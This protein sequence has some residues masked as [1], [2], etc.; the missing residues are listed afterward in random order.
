MTIF[1]GTLPP[2]PEG[3][4]FRRF[5]SFS[6]LAALSSGSKGPADAGWPLHGRRMTGGPRRDERRGA[7][8]RRP[9]AIAYVNEMKERLERFARLSGFT[10]ACFDELASTNDTARDPRYG[11]GDVVLAE[12]QTAGRG[13]R[14]NSWSSGTGLNLT[15]SVVLCPEFLP[16]ARQF[17]VSKV[18]AL[19]VSDTL[20][21][22]GIGARIKWPNDIYIGDRKTAGILIENDLCGGYMARSV[23]GVGLNV[24]QTRFDASLPNPVSMA[25]AAGRSFDRAE[26]FETFYRCLS[27]RYGALA[28]ER[29]RSIDDD[30]LA[31]LYRL[32][33]RHAFVDGRTGARFVGTI[34]DVLPAGD[35][36]VG[37][38]SGI[39]RYLFKEIEYVIGTQPD[40]RN[41]PEG[42]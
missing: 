10:A 5:S 16:A 40:G 6:G 34:R 18:V 14:G 20:A 24:N 13:Q 41:F 22:W 26:V 1:G 19:A 27:E 11:A 3:G 2:F 7:G 33:E 31:R 25:L 32:G 15:F 8:S 17:Y 37:T 30:Y 4:A 36:V 29:D 38:G 35:L 28:E 23:V 9:V 21:R 39:R 12:R 42:M